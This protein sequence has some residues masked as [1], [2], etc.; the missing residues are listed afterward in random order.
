MNTDAFDWDAAE[1]DFAARPRE[2]VKIPIGFD[3]QTLELFVMA[4]R[5]IESETPADINDISWAVEYLSM[6]T[7]SLEKVLSGKIR[8]A[9]GVQ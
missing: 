9:L 7:D 5:I 2:V 1:A 8:E 6:F 4:Q 3:R